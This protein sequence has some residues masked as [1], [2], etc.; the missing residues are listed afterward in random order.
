[1]KGLWTQVHRLGFSL[2][3]RS[4]GHRGLPFPVSKTFLPIFSS[5]FNAL[6]LRWLDIRKETHA[7]TCFERHSILRPG[8]KQRDTGSL[9]GFRNDLFIELAEGRVLGSILLRRTRGG[10]HGVQFPA[11]VELVSASA[12]LMPQGNV[13][14]VACAL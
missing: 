8:A 5:P 1:V 3:E 11:F 9:G 14:A 7:P 13:W 10:A 12:R 2:V 6:G 4:E